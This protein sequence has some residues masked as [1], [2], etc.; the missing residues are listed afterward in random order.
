MADPFDHAWAAIGADSELGRARQQ[1]SVHELRTIIRHCAGAFATR[2]LRDPEWRTDLE[3]APHSGIA[4]FAH[5]GRRMA[6]IYWANG[7]VVSEPLG[8]QDVDERRPFA[9]ILWM[10]VPPVNLHG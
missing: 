2:I 4:I 5:D 1:L 9:P 3:A 8:D 6:V 7:W 10:H